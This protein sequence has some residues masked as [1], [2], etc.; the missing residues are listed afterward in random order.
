MYKEGGA[1]QLYPDKWDEFVSVIPEAERGGDLIAAFAKRLTGSDPAEQLRAA[2]AWSKWEGDIVTLLPH[3]EVIEEFTEDDKAIAI[4]RIE[5]HYMANNGWLEDGQLL[6]D[7]GKLKGIP[8][9]IVQGRHD[10]CTPPIAAWQ[11]KKAWPEVELNIVPDGG[12]LYNEPGVLDGLI[13]ATDKFA[14]R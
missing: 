6:R 4:A 11:L 14:D 5:N 7:A 3:P 2:K 8:G 10:C 1:S 9:V 13:R 12:H